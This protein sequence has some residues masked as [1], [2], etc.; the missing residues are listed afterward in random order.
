MS[1]LID[2]QSSNTQ[3]YPIVTIEP[4][5][6]HSA[7][8]PTWPD[9]FPECI[10][11]S[12]NSVN[13]KHIHA[14]VTGTTT[15]W[16]SLIS[17]V[18]FKPL[19]S[20]MPTINQSIDIKTRKFKVSNVTVNILNNE[21]RGERFSDLFDDKSLINWLVSIQ[22]VSPT[23]NHFSTTFDVKEY[24]LEVDSNGTAIPESG[25]ES[26]YDRYIRTNAGGEYGSGGSPYMT[27]M[28]YQGRI[29]DAYQNKESVTLK[30]EDILG[31]KG[32]GT[33]PAVFTGHSEKIPEKYQG[34]PVPI[35]FGEVKRSPLVMD[36]IDGELN[37]ICDS[38]DETSKF[39]YTEDDNSFL[40]SNPLK[41]LRDEVY[42]E[43]FSSNDDIAHAHTIIEDETPSY[44]DTIQYTFTNDSPFI[45]IYKDS[46][47]A[48]INPL[49]DNIA[50]CK[51]IHNADNWYVHQSEDNYTSYHHTTNYIRNE[52]QGNIFTG[53]E[54]SKKA[55]TATDP[56]GQAYTILQKI[57]RFD[58]G[59]PAAP[60]RI[61][62]HSKGA[63]TATL[64]ERIE[65]HYSGY[66]Y[67][68]APIRVGTNGYM[69]LY[70]RTTSVNGQ[71]DFSGSN[72]SNFIYGG[73]TETVSLDIMLGERTEDIGDKFICRVESS[74]YPESD[75]EIWLEWHM[76]NEIYPIWRNFHY[77]IS[78]FFES[79]F[80]GHVLGRT[81][82]TT[83]IQNPITIMKYIVETFLD[84]Q[85]D[86]ASYDIALAEHVGWTFNFTID[87]VI[88]TK[89][90]LEDMAKSTK[91]FIRF[92]EAGKLAFHTIKYYYLATDYTNAIA[93][94]DAISYIFKLSDLSEIPSKMDVAYSKDHGLDKYL[95]KTD[96]YEFSA[97]QLEYYGIEFNS[98]I[99]HKE[100]KSDYITNF[101]TAI[102]LLGFN[103][104]W[105]RN[106]RLKAELTLGLN[107]SAITVG[108]LIKFPKLLG[109]IKSQGIDYSTLELLNGQWRYPLFMVTSVKLGTKDVKIKAEQIPAIGEMYDS[110]N[111]AELILDNNLT[112]T[113]EIEDEFGIQTSQIAINFFQELS[114]ATVTES[115]GNFSVT[116]LGATSSTPAIQFQ[117]PTAIAKGPLG[118]LCPWLV[119][120]M[121]AD[122]TTSIVTSAE[123]E[124]AQQAGG[125]ELEI[126]TQATL[127]SGINTLRYRTQSSS[128]ELDTYQDVTVA[129]SDGTYVNTLA[130]EVVNDGKFINVDYHPSTG[131]GIYH[132][133]EG[134]GAS[135]TAAYYSQFDE[136]NASRPL[137][138]DCYLQSGSSGGY[139]NAFAASTTTD[140]NYNM[141]DADIE[142]FD[143]VSWGSYNSL[144]TM[145]GAP[146]GW[147]IYFYWGG[148]PDAG[149]ITEVN[150]NGIYNKISWRVVVLSSEDYATFL[151]HWNN[152][153]VPGAIRS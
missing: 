43:V 76:D 140:S 64:Q 62:N 119:E 3:I 69:V 151:T 143:T 77:F 21:Y 89:D 136:T 32:H 38:V 121:K 87:E 48:T 149:F 57:L 94:D 93:I 54:I 70:F 111:W 83:L 126:I 6:A 86:Q 49:K 128:P 92:D 50:Y 75:G 13:L 130:A 68:T 109:G 106:R 113:D 36:T 11:L 148:Q 31:Q 139:M 150:S 145:A 80:Y 7:T 91:C 138:I 1:F 60:G 152:D 67:H 59:F 85:V 127:W 110:D 99:A 27:Q 46:G 30:L 9:V 147:K 124:D 58:L 88:N 137:N 35:V 40:T 47:G 81:V 90:L 129:Y 120:I 53:V 15:S 122:G 51:I 131:N 118:S 114:G 82:G 16:E 45:K 17:N 108:S 42:V 153:N 14:N 71:P 84:A 96:T 26:F 97:E 112:L 23:G 115:N 5:R 73:E 144:G 56:D 101:Q 72:H 117:F 132:V 134:E 98:D 8:P 79:D 52:N 123:I 133:I 44:T 66:Y 107:H 105:N 135:G 65:I 34:R 104:N 103:Y 74:I 10:F 33:I 102:K 28:V 24:P 116:V 55:E 41:I 125:N 95:Q 22:L 142:Y 20:G 18:S 39:Y 141:T 37:A 12:T 146:S 29:R 19:L 78:D 63:V 100:L 61:I 4:P 2:T 25:F